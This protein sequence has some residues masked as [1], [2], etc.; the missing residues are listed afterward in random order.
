MPRVSLVRCVS[1][2][3]LLLFTA[4]AHAAALP[5]GQAAGSLTI[6]GKPLQLRYAIAVTGPDTFDETKEAV[7]LLLTP[8]PVTQASI[9]KAAKF[10]D[11]RSLADQGIAYK[12]RLGD[13]FHL[14]ARHPILGERELQT[15]GSISD[16]KIE[17]DSASVTG[18]IVP[19]GGKEEDMFEHKVAYNIAFNAPIARRFALDKLVVMSPNAKKLGSGGGA[20]GKAWIDEK[21]ATPK[22]PKDPKEAEATLAKEGALPS[23]AELNKQGTTRAAYVKDVLALASTLAELQTTDCKVLGGLQDDEYAIIQVEGTSVKMRQR[24]DVTMVKDPAKGWKVKKEGAWT[25]LEEKK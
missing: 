2:I 14:T 12:V 16:S 24:T 6:D 17:M 22:I 9:D 10:D 18:N 5:S 7:M 15:S 3:F 21:C 13:H 19:F 20:P 4:V 11:I 1:L 25:V 23:D 8:K